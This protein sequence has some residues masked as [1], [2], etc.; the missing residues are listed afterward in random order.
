MK[1]LRAEF[2]LLGWLPP[3][4][5]DVLRLSSIWLSAVGLLAAGPA[6]ANWYKASTKHFI[7]YADEKP[8]TLSDFAE[9]LEMFDQAARIL[10]R[11]DDP[12]VGDGNRLTVYVLP[13]DNDVRKLVGDKSGFL[14]G[15]YTGRVEGSLAYI[16]KRANG[17]L[18]AQS[19]IYHEYTH[20]LMMQQLDQPYPE[21]YVEGFAEFLS[22][23]IFGTDG[24]VGLGTPQ[25][26]RMWGLVGS[27][28]QMPL[29]QMLGATYGEIEKLP[30]DLRESIY[31]RGW[32]L[33]HYLTMEPKRQGQL[34]RYILGIANGTPPLASAQAAF[35]DLK[36][37]DR[38]LGTYLNRST[39]KY[40][41]ISGN[42]IHPVPVDVQLLSPGAA[43][44]V[45]LRGEMKFDGKI[46]N[47]AQYTAQARAIEARYPGDALVEATLAEAE[48][49]AGDA[50]AAAAAADR[51]L[52]ADPRS[53]EPMILKGRAIEL[54]AKDADSDQRKSMF[55][56][57]RDTF[58]AAN[59]LDT[60]DPEPLFEYYMS[61]MHEGVRPTANAIDA[62]HYAS[63]LAPQDISVRMN[64]AISYLEE[65]KPKDARTTLTL[66]A[67]SPHAPQAAGVAKR[68]IADIDGGNSKAALMELRRSPAAQSSGD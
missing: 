66:V 34:S 33:V 46:T 5:G 19:V 35:G 1:G 49:D 64:S 67:F 15:F 50:D 23:P 53:T 11:M 3:R 42:A 57:A 18:G 22:S 25:E 38:E 17:D 12:A 20:H 43:Q 47:G 7:V 32:L 65:G 45:L 37:L 29:D 55:D 54:K 6:H 51:A 39:M 58:I 63:D 36:Q 14:D 56:Q 44:I 13:T 16:P 48:L 41:K 59:K 68:M 4:K 28:R 30:N 40:F 21:W 9:R 62:L 10:L 8:K 52:K 26:A 61:Y 27:A 60:E 24:S 31:E 2:G